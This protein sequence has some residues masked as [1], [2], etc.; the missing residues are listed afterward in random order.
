MG[1]KLQSVSGGSV[2]L[3]SPITTNNY[4]V[5]MHPSR[6]ASSMRRSKLFNVPLEL[7]PL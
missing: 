5:T 4:V 2:E 3:N 6:T 1:L 7:Q